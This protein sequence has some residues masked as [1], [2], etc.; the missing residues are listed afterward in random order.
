MDLFFGLATV[1]GPDSAY[2]FADQGLFMI[3]VAGSGLSHLISVALLVA[4]G[5]SL[6]RRRDVGPGRHDHPRHAQRAQ[7]ASRCC[8]ARPWLVA[9]ASSRSTSSWSTH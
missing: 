4:V 2:F 5:V 1:I 8:S 9:G 3:D 6:H 7:A